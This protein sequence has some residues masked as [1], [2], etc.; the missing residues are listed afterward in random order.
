MA[1][2]TFAQIPDVIAKYE[3]RMEAVTK[4]SAQRVA[5]E[6]KRRTRRKTGFLRASLLASTSGMPIIDRDARPVEGA[7]YADDDSQ[8]AL[9]IAGAS[10]GQTIFLGFTASYA[11]PR[12]YYDGMVRLTAQRWPSI[13]KEVVKDALARMP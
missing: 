6:V 2:Y 13:V 9:V 3:R 1:T 4:E 8:I 7:P 11:R 5:I 10:L 12:E